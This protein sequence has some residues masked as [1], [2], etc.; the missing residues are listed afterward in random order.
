MV[1]CMGGDIALVVARCELSGLHGMSLGRCDRHRGFRAVTG[2]G[3]GSFMVDYSPEM[4]WPLDII[5]RVYYCS[6]WVIVYGI[7]GGDNDRG[8]G[9]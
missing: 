7:T 5:S 4:V 3:G 9:L 1:S 6:I 2:V 8:G